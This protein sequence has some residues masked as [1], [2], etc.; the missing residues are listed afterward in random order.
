MRGE[1]VTERVGRSPAV[2]A[3]LLEMLF[4]HPGDAA[5]GE[6]GAEAVGEDGRVAARFFARREF[7]DGEPGFQGACGVGADRGEA[8]AFA[9]ATN[10]HD[11]GCEVEG[12]VVEADQRAP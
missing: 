2:E 11:A 8:F 1:A 5:G 9:F 10:P 7:A 3:G 4:E 6:A 12:A